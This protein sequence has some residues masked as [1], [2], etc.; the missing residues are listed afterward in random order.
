MQVLYICI[1]I[2]MS[3][4]LEPPCASWKNLQIH[5]V[6]VRIT[7]EG[8][9]ALQEDAKTLAYGPWTEG[10]PV[11]GTPY[12]CVPLSDGAAGEGVNALVHELVWQAFHGNV[13]SGWF[14]GHQWDTPIIDGYY[15]NDLY[16]L[17]IYKKVVEG[18]LKTCPRRG[19][20]VRGVVD[21]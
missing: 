20:V 3:D 17:S 6:V 14:V 1:A 15:A 19:T 12:R 8:N 9:I 18:G 2:M 16:N 4:W 5:G 13:P 11:V 10:L 21:E 7:E